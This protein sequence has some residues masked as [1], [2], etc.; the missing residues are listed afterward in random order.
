MDKLL[1]KVKDTLHV[2]NVPATIKAM[3]VLSAQ[4][5]VEDALFLW[6]VLQQN[7][8]QC[9]LFAWTAYLTVLSSHGQSELAR[10]SIKEMVL[11]GVQPDSYVY[12]TVVNGLV[13]EHK[14]EEAYALSRS[15]LQAGLR[16]NNVVISSLL[17]GCIASRQ[18]RRADETFDLLR[19]YVEEPDAITL[20]LMIK[21]SDVCR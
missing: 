11:S 21:V 15:M 7:P 2:D 3:R 9:T 18:L 14:L 10:D 20:S 12:G 16:P 13:R 4:D 1:N 17:C 8:K 19:N 5:R 6:K